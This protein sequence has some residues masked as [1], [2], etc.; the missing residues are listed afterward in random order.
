MQIRV[1]GGEHTSSQIVNLTLKGIAFAM[2]NR[3]YWFYHAQVELK[4]M[5]QFICWKSD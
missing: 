5:K 1:T 3:N 2:G 4:Q